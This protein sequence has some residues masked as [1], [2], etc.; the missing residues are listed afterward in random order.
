MGTD[1]SPEAH[2][3]FQEIDAELVKLCAT[4]QGAAFVAFV[5]RIFEDSTQKLIEFGEAVAP[6][7]IEGAKDLLVNLATTA[8]TSELERLN[9]K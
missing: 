6:L 9:K 8:I 2:A 5:K 3:K 7:A 1:M 4:P